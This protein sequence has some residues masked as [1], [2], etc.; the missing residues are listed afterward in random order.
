MN[1]GYAKERS[2]FYYEVSREQYPKSLPT[3]IKITFGKAIGTKAVRRV[4]GALAPDLIEAGDPYHL[5]WAALRA[6][7]DRGVPV[8]RRRSASRRGWWVGAAS[9]IKNPSM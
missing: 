9:P 4:L 8:C 3:L 7:A 5:A 2:G 1:W 6:G